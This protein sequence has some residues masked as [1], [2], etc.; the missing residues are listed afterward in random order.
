M[1]VSST[2]L[3]KLALL[4]KPGMKVSVEIQFG[5]EDSYAFHTTLIGHKIDQHIILDLPLKAHQAL[6]MR[7]LKN[8][9]IVLRGMCDT[10]LGHIVAF[11]SSILQASTKPFC[12]LFMRPPKHFATKAIRSHERY[13]IAIPAELNENNRSY[14][15]TLIDFSISGCGV[16]IDGENELNKGSKVRI[17]S[18]LDPFLPK[19]I[20]SQIVNIRRQSNGHLI[21]IQFDQ[22]ITLTETLKKQVLEQAFLAGSI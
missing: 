21:G 17:N 14:S 12:M 15:G 13:K 8:V 18:E 11:Q 4:L 20:K 2:D 6:V 3:N 22:P 1:T 16:F 19:R 9:H 7:K 10:E 5:P